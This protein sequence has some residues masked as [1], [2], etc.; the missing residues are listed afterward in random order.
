MK[1]I[2]HP[3]D[4]E[5]EVAPDVA[6]RD[7]GRGV[8]ASSKKKNHDIQEVL[9]R[10]YPDAS[11]DINPEGTDPNEDVHVAVQLKDCLINISRCLCM[12]HIFRT[13]QGSCIHRIIECW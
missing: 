11:Q 4:Y 2:H 1:A 12:F 6:R 7:I 3:I 5:D 8:A 10:L 9:L 13:E